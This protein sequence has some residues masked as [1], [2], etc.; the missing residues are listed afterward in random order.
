MGAIADRHGQD[1]DI[2]RRLKGAAFVEA[3]MQSDDVQVVVRTWSRIEESTAS[4]ITSVLLLVA[5]GKLRCRRRAP[6]SSSLRR[7]QAVSRCR[8]LD[9]VVLSW[10]LLVMTPFVTPLASAASNIDC[11]TFRTHMH[12]G[13]MFRRLNVGEF[14]AVF[15]RLVPACAECCG[16]V[17]T[18]R[19][20]KRWRGCCRHVPKKMSRRTTTRTMCAPFAEK[21]W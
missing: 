9:S 13:P 11:H 4:V 12:N 18:I 1:D 20:K 16:L 5:A 17:P 2:C 19:W 14:D 8:A 3:E 10:I 7:T 21:R 6:A 15:Q